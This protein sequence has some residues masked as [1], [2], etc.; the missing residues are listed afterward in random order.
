MRRYLLF[1]TATTLLVASCSNDADETTGG[2]QPSDKAIAFD[3]ADDGQTRAPGEIIEDGT[4]NLVAAGGFGVFACYTGKLTYENT[5]VSPDF[6]Y[7][8][9][10]TGTKDSEGNITWSYKPVKYW[11]NDN[12]EYVSFFA[13]APYENAPADN[14][15]IIDLSKSYD[16]GDPWLN[17]RLAANPWDATNGQVDLLY[18]TKEGTGLWTDLQR[19]DTGNKLKFTFHHALACIGDKITIKMSEELNE[20]LTGY[21]D[22]TINKITV[23][24]KHLTTKGRLILRSDG[25]A[26]NWKEIISG[27]I[28]TA[29]T[30]TKNVSIS[31]PKDGGDNT[32]DK[33]IST[34]DG[35]FYIPLRIAGQGT[36]CAEVTITYTVRNNASSSYSGTATTTF[37]LDMSLEGKK[38]GI[39]LQLTKTLDLQHLVYEIGTGATEPSYSRQ[40]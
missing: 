31:F 6:M 8:Q 30:Y 11:P 36:A 35:L 27:E 39:A 40:R 17:Y 5:T 9:H 38:Q 33:E 7:N 10:V 20:L 29:R 15:C 25:G 24:Y 37:P 28:T 18:G 19:P 34:G 22:I 1:I 4:N 32:S 23:D 3:V 2:Y 14:K 12:R 21:A 16:L 13:Y 26:A